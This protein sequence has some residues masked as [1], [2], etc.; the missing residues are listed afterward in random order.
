MSATVGP[1][2]GNAVAMPPATSSP[3]A[4]IIAFMGA[5]A[6]SERVPDDRPAL[7]E[8]VEEAEQRRQ[9]AIASAGSAQIT[10]HPR[11]LLEVAVLAVAMEE[12]RKN[13]EHLELSLHAHPFEVAPEIGEV[14]A[15][16][17][18]GGASRLPEAHGPID[19][20]LLVPFDVG[21]AQQRH[22]IVGHRPVDR[23]LEI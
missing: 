21:A 16:R 1:S 2:S 22:E 20:V 3:A 8:R 17:K 10:H 19:L 11:H 5:P 7:L 15:Y 23:T 13:A 9:I 14:T 6:D 4:R 18:A 12:P